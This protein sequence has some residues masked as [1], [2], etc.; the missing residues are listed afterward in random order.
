MKLDVFMLTTIDN[1]FNPFTQ[2]DE[3]YRYDMGMLYGTCGYLARIAKTTPEMTDE[4]EQ[5]ELNRAMD[6][7]CAVNPLGI[8][9][10]VSIDD[11]K[12][13]KWHA[14]KLKIDPKFAKNGK[15]TPSEG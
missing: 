4:E 13:G 9:K 11:Y 10:K 1:P 8:H 15:N 14:K 12:H 3:W 7:I 6:E 2:F 5:E